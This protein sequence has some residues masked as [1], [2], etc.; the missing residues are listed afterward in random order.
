L[1]LCM[2]GQHEVPRSGSWF[3]GVRTVREDVVELRGR[4][5]GEAIGNDRV[6]GVA[7]VLVDQDFAVGRGHLGEAFAFQV[8][9]FQVGMVERR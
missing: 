4:Y 9:V 7:L 1:G 8:F 6:V 2:R 3:V 5:D